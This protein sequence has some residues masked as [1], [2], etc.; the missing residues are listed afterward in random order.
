M[1]I[2]AE[3]SEIDHRDPPSPGGLF[4]VGARSRGYPLIREEACMSRSAA[5]ALLI[6]CIALLFVG[7]VI[8]SVATSW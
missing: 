6:T 8:W 1:A 7:L 2:G 5:A 4:V 3:R